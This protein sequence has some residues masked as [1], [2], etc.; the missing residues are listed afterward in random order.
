MVAREIDAPAGV[1]PVVWRL[2]TNRLAPD[3]DA[4]IELIDWY[5]CR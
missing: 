2:V 3:R 4:V 1:K 5:R